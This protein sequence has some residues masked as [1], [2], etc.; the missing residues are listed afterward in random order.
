MEHELAEFLLGSA[1]K[2]HRSPHFCSAI[3]C[4]P[5]FNTLMSTF[6]R[7]TESSLLLFYTSVVVYSNVHAILF[8]LSVRDD[9]IAAIISY[10]FVMINDSGQCK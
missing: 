9:K 10:R 5:I 3:T 8:K 6:I 1:A 4:A 2:T 7:Y